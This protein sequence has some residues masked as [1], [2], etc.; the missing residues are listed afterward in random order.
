MRSFFDGSSSAF[1]KHVNARSN[2]SL[3]DVSLNGFTQGHSK[4]CFI[5]S[6]PEGRCAPFSMASAMPSSAAAAEGEEE[7]DALDVSS[8]SLSLAFLR[9]DMFQSKSG[10]VLR[11][12][13]VW[14][15][16]SSNS[17]MC[18]TLKTKSV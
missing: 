18:V 9:E 13:K 14:G 15:L 10:F 7:G 4:A 5:L 3:H 6:S 2:S 12:Q 8:S 11:T 17:L 1:I 16:C